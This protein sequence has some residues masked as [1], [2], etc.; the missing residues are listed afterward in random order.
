MPEEYAYNNYYTSDLIVAPIVGFCNC[1]MFCCALLCAHSSFA[2]TLMGKRERADCF[3]LFVFLMSRD[4]CVALPR[5]A[6]T[7]R[8]CIFVECA[9]FL[10]SLF[11]QNKTNVLFREIAR[12]IARNSYAYSIKRLYCFQNTLPTAFELLHIKE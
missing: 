1:S 2:V 12:L 3:A 7:A 11:Q 8:L 10:Q 4:C 9:K 6:S 5:S